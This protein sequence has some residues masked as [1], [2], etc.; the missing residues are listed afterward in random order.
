MARIG[1]L[2]G[3][4]KLP[5]LFSQVAKS[6]G[7]TVI[8]FALKGQAQQELAKYVDKIHWLEWGEYQKGLLLLAAERIRKVAMLGKISKEAFF[9]DDDKLDEKAKKVIEKIRDKKDYSILNEMGKVLGKIG[10][11]VIDP[12]TY[13]SDLIP[14]KGILT[15]KGPSDSE[16]DDINYGVKMAKE[17]SGFDIG[18]TVVVKDKTVIAV[19]AI[20]GTDQTISRAGALTKG[21]FVVVKVARPNQDMR[22]DVPLVGL[23]TL[24]AIAEAKGSALAL[25]SGKM[26][27]M[28]REALVNLADEKGISIV[29]I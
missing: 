16:S 15:K 20:E 1:L 18:Q 17:L 21:G 14:Q 9:K 29:V 2:A 13:L 22:F 19:E 5:I 10:I 12:T 6:R 27:L 3:Y 11:E 28:D 23:D 7:D 4:G 26:L 8:A 24:K 25:E